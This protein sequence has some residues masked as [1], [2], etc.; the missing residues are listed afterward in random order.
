LKKSRHLKGLPY[1]LLLGLSGLLL[2]AHAA[3]IKCWKN[4]DG[5]RECGFAIPPEYAQKRVE[6]LNDRGQVTEVIE[7]AKTPEERERDRQRQA[8]LKIQQDKIQAERDYDRVLL[9]T[10]T[11][12]RD[13]QIA[14]ENQA[15]A[16]Q[17]IINIAEGN[18]KVQRSQFEQL[19]KQAGNFERSGKPV[20]E[21]L[22][23]EIDKLSTMM[24]ESEQYLDKK[25]QEKKQ[26]L[27]KFDQD[28]KRLQGLWKARK[29]L[30]SQ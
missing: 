11:T 1:L 8:E 17:A 13:L 21:K 16:A 5:V 2:P 28:L 23:S 22:V 10:Y 29:Q 6:I 15:N 20:P 26:I 25:N 27:D 30:R 19:T 3:S 7:A 9:Q 14:R 4:S 18:L 24:K 12:E